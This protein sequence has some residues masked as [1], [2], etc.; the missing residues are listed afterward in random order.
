MTPEQLEM[1]NNFTAEEQTVTSQDVVNATGVSDGTVL[2]GYSRNYDHGHERTYTNHVYMADG[3]LHLV[4]YR[5]VRGGYKLVRH[6]T[7]EVRVEDACPKKRIY[8]EA[9]NYDFAV[10]LRDRG[11]D[12]SL[13]NHNADRPVAQFYGY[14][15]EEFPVS[16]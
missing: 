1:L 7:G 10:L 4:D 6:V 9:T 12:L 3:V 2:Y 8:P 15:A 5:P 16:R 14:R 11:G 13:T